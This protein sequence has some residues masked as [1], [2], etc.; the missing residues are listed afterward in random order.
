MNLKVLLPFDIFA[1]KKEV[2]LVVIDTSGGS[3]G[4]LPHRLDCV[5]AL[6]PG[7]LTYETKNDGTVYVAVDEGV[8]VKVGAEVLVSV[9]Q[10]IAGSDLSKLHDAVKQEF[11]KL[12][13]REQ[14]VRTAIHKMETGLDWPTSRSFNMDDELTNQPTKEA[15]GLR[16]RSA[17]PSHTQAAATKRRNTRC[18][19][20]SRDVRTDWLVRCRAYSDW[21]DAWLVAGPAPSWNAFLDADVVGHWFGNRVRQCL[22]MGRSARQGHA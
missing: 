3:F 2:S 1:D 21:R 14:T 7:I 16:P 5:A 13:E 6:V 15:T 20:W 10:A 22:A 19:V 9:R 17:R 18:V 12:N 8:L 4:I 11:L